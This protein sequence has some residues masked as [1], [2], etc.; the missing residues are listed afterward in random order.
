MSPTSICITELPVGTWTKPYE[1][2]LEKLIES[3]VIKDF[4]SMSTEVTV[5]IQVQF[6]N[7]DAL[8]SLETQMYPNQV[9]G[10]EK[11]LE[12][13]TTESSTNIHM[14]NSVGKLH[15]YIN[16]GEI[17]DEFSNVRIS[18]YEKRRLAQIDR[19]RAELIRLSNHALYIIKVLDGSIDL[20]RKNATQVDEL[21]TGHGLVRLEGNYT[22][23]TKLPMD[24]VTSENVESI[25][26]KKANKEH[27]LEIMMGLT[28]R[29]MWL[30]ELDELEK[31][32]MKY[33]LRR[34]NL[35]QKE[36]VK[37][38]VVVRKK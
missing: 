36:P 31:E 18:T 13:T 27:E 34:E 24:S 29:K 26:Q 28:P 38:P 2:V 11:M 22:Y 32:Y 14:F 8:T 19:L 37:K 7:A 6:S 33:K 3:S 16:A 23:L 1:K 25:L 10:I 21:L 30:S 17:I 9:N 5:N 35:Q 15:K 20:R 4:T 12:L